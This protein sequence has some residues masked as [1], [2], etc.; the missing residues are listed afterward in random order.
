MSLNNVRTNI[1]ARLTRTRGISGSPVVLGV[2]TAVACLIVIL[3]WIGALIVN[4]AYVR[5]LVGIDADIY[6]NATRSWLQDGQWYL[7]RQLT[8]PYGI[9]YGDVLYPPTLLY[10]LVP[11]QWLPFALWWAIPMGAIA[12]GLWL[13]RPPRWSWPL[14]VLCLAWPMSVEQLIK[15]NPVLWVMAIATIC[16][17]RSWPLTLVLLKPSLAPFALPGIHRRSWWIVLGLMGLATVP[18]W[19]LAILYPHVILNSRGGGLLYSVRDCA[20]VA[21]VARDAPRG[22]ATSAGSE[23]HPG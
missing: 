9:E 6:F 22:K 14:L 10:I 1:G 5:W 23:D 4:P 3:P 12:I 17:A 7:P 2:L 18:F 16:L 21:S 15:G 13:M 11:F 20:R 8:G 19:E